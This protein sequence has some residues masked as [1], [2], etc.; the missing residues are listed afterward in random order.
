M[1]QTESMNVHEIREV[2]ARILRQEPIPDD[3]M[4]AAR[5]AFQNMCQKAAGYDLTTADVVRAVL[6]PMFA[7]TQ[8]CDCWGCKSRRGEL[9]DEKI[10]DTT[11][12]VI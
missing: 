2:V 9:N 10:L 3:S 8:G 4:L 12:P 6:R 7:P 1:Q 11:L 5:D